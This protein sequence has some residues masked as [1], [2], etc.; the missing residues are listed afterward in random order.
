MTKNNSIEY[1]ANESLRE[2][3]QSL[4][5]EFNNYTNFVAPPPNIGQSGHNNY[6]TLNSYQPDTKS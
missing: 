3:D 1:Y 4:L 6:Y 2:P 5:N